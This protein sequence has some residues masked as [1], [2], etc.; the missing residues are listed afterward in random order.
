[1]KLLKTKDQEKSYNHPEKKV[2]VLHREQLC[3]TMN[4]LPEIMEAESETTFLKC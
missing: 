3:K 4:F 1:M 2:C